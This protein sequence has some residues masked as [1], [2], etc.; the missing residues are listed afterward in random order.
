MTIVD[1]A[2]QPQPQRQSSADVHNEAELLEAL[3]A[4]AHKVQANEEVQEGQEEAE[5]SK[6]RRRR[7]RQRSRATSTSGLP[8]C[9][10]QCAHG[11]K[12]GR[13]ASALPEPCLEDGS[14]L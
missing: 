12:H 2:R 5:V 13:S 10:R 14:W 9:W 8:I 11:T 4:T 3:E 7:P 6:I 1:R